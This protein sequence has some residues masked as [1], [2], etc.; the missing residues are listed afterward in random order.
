MAHTFKTDFLTRIL[1]LICLATALPGGIAAAAPGDTTRVSVSS[2]G[3]Q[4]ND[5][6]RWAQISGD[7]NYVAFE[8][9]ASSLVSGDTNGE[10]DIFVY[11]RQTRVTERVSVADDESQA[12]SWSESD[13]GISRDGRYVAFGSVASN[14]VSGDTNGMMDVFVRDRL[15]GRTLR[16]SVDSSGAQ[17]SGDPSSEYGG[18][19]IS[20]DGRFVTFTSEVST[21]VNND[22]NGVADAFVHD[23]Q[24]GATIRVSVSSSGEQ[25]NGYSAS[26]D[27][28][29][30]GHLVVFGS[31]ATNLVSADTNGVSDVFV[32][33]LLTDETRR[34][35]I[36]SIGDQANH[37]ANGGVISDNGRYVAFSSEADN[38]ALNYEI[39]EHVYIHDL[40]TWETTR[41]S[42]WADGSPMVGWAE[43]P[44]ISADGRYVAFEW[45]DRGDGMP[46][47]WIYVRDRGTGQTIMIT[48]GDSEGRQS[49]FNPSLS[50]DGRFLSFDSEIANLVSGD[51]NGVRDVFVR[52]GPFASTPIPTATPSPLPT[53]TPL[54]NLVPTVVSI[55]RLDPNPTYTWQN[56][57]YAERAT[58]VRQ[59][60][61]V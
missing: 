13:L 43:T 56:V 45:D 26:S 9:Y 34:V 19:A 55:N 21:L 29:D 12:N 46:T 58:P 42:V 25:G 49:P 52:E 20:G 3:A 53:A 41:V 1:V 36:S 48:R 54:P 6:S 10:P 27:I 15:Q 5:M 33:N 39:W 23:L 44:A 57:R 18:I 17:V 50:A 4:G 37:A 22:T 60:S 7:G 47:R 31:S 11:N 8:S 30:D 24:T 16:V 38:L 59:P 51:T 2:S 28:S 61:Q 35:S 40:E 32:H 14:L